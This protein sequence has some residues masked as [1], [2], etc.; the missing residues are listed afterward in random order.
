MIPDDI[1]KT[2]N[3]PNADVRVKLEFEI[4]FDQDELKA[5]DSDYDFWQ[6]VLDTNPMTVRVISAELVQ[7]EPS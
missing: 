5:I 6:L 1:M 7:R 4:E 2:L 3:L